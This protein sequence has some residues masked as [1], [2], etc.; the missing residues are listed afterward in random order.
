M[1][2]TDLELIKKIK[3]KE[4]ENEFLSELIERHKKLFYSIIERRIRSNKRFPSHVVDEVVD[5]INLV[6]YKAIMNFDETRNMKFS[7]YLGQ[8]CFWFSCKTYE[9]YACKVKFNPLY[10]EKIKENILDSE[11][12]NNSSYFSEDELIDKIKQTINELNNEKEQKILNLRYLKCKGKKLPTWN[13]IGEIMQLEPK[14]CLYIHN[15]AIKK[16]KSILKH[17]NEINI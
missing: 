1:N 15:K 2:Y 6:F 16:I 13:K 11:K 4:N 10:H 14:A 3:N 7:T 12:V 17:K 9:S 5:S 8:W